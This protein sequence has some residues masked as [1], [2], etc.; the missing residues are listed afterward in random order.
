MARGVYRVVGIGKFDGLTLHRLNGYKMGMEF[1]VSNFNGRDPLQL[2]GVAEEAWKAG[3][4]IYATIHHEGI[5][6]SGLP[7]NPKLE[8]IF[9]KT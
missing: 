2:K 4:R 5:S 7:I 9:S 8:N 3:H 6:A 1:N